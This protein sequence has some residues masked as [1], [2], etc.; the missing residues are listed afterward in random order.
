MSQADTWKLSN[1]KLWM[2]SPFKDFILIVGT[3]LLILPAFAL[4]QSAV[5]WETLC[6]WVASFGAMGHHLPGMIRAYGDRDLFNRFKLRFIMAPILLVLIC[7]LWFKYDLKVIMLIAVVWGVWHG[8]MQ[9]YGF[10]RIYDSKAGSFEKTTSR[11]D[12]LMTLS[13]FTAA[14]L[15]S[16]HHMNRLLE[17][18]YHSGGPFISVGTIT[19][20]RWASGIF[21]GLVTLAFIANLIRQI[22]VGRPPSPVK[23]LVMVSGIGFWTYTYSVISN[24]IIGIALFEVF[25]DFQYLTIVW[26]F[27]RGRVRTQGASVGNFFKF[28]F[29]RSGALIGV[30]LGAIFAYGS[31]NLFT[32]LYAR[33]TVH[34]VLSGIALAS[35]LLHFYYDGFI[36]KIREKETAQTLHLET[37]ESLRQKIRA[38]M[39]AWMPHTLRWSLLI[40]PAAV[41]TAMQFSNQQPAFARQQALVEALP[42]NAAGIYTYAQA[43]DERGDV[44]NAVRYYQQVIELEPDHADALNNLG[45]A[46][47]VLGDRKAAET[48]FRESVKYGPNM[49]EP[50]LN[51]ASLLL[52]NRKID[53]AI[54]FFK[55]AETIDPNDAIVQNNLGNALLVKGRNEEAVKRFERAIEL[56]PDYA[57]PHYNLGS[58]HLAAGL[59]ARAV[60]HFQAA[61]KANPRSVE[62][63]NGLGEALT[64]LGDRDQAMIKFQAAAQA[65]PGFAR[66]WFNM[67]NLYAGRQDFGNAILNYQKALQCNP[68]FI[69]AAHNMATALAMSGRN[70]EAARLFEAIL[71]D[72]P[73]AVDIHENLVVLYKRLGDDDK[74]EAHRKAAEMLRKAAAG[75][76]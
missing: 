70:A 35:A 56:K 22:K 75:R 1:P 69:Q 6:F 76:G 45:K 52:G 30:Y 53:E 23:I 38:G 8:Q 28:I 65:N 50:H 13:W 31:V 48:Y 47:L 58:I 15:F 29:G 74:A 25:H 7:T 10:M 11:I 64:A 27:N 16:N 42:D 19:A 21:T 4:A 57:S 49:V 39:P 60:D 59:H 51:L 34:Q 71:R 63:L 5:H 2:I 66:T 55:K 14:V 41:L 72:K 26:L 33:G 12:F 20:L 9:T 24:P 61:I 36:W 54:G 43:L 37:S 44:E 17:Y 62:A 68:D 18:F 73:Q 32:E 40:V 3:P 46:V 67:G